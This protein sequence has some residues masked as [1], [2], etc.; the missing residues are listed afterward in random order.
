VA[1]ATRKPTAKPQTETPPE[2][3]AEA[4]PTTTVEHTFDTVTVTVPLVDLIPEQYSQRHVD[5]QLS[6][7]RANTLKRITDGLIASKQRTA[8]GRPV[9]SA[10]DAVRW[11]LDGIAAANAEAK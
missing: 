5:L 3:G 2:V 7:P 9:T 6:E 4:G 8:D 10:A 11:W 1:N